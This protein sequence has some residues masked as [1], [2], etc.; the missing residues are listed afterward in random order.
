MPYIPL[1]DSN[2]I[3]LNIDKN[4]VQY[5]AT[6][7]ELIIKD[8]LLVMDGAIR[9]INF[10]KHYNSDYSI[11]NGKVVFNIS[12]YYTSEIPAMLLNNK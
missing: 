1:E 4:F 3:Q 5:N 10:I 12:C 9:L 7:K 6:T 8:Q 2:E 11:T